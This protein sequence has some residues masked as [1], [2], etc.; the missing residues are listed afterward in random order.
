VFRAGYQIRNQHAVHFLTFTVIQWIDVFTRPNYAEILV[1]SIKFCQK[2]KNFKLHAW[3]LMFNHLHLLCSSDEPNKLSDTLRDMKQFTSKEIIKA[4][5][6]NKQESRKNWMLWLFESSGRGNPRN[7][8]V[9]FW[10]QSNHPI[11]CDTQEMLDS[12]LN[13]IHENPV[14]SKIVQKAEDYNFCSAM[15]YYK[16]QNIGKLKIDFV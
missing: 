15:D 11:E 1:D 13:Y 14:K 3:C 5:K 9:Q 10:Q 8:D 6:N 4:I 16:G 2:N 7:Q 12:R